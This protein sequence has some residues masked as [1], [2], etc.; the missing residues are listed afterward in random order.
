MTHR[1]TS[2]NR[3]VS[4]QK[5]LIRTSIVV[6]VCNICWRCTSS[7][8]LKFFLCCRDYFYLFVCVESLWSLWRGVVPAAGTTGF[9]RRHWWV[10]AKAFVYCWWVLTRSINTSRAVYKFNRCTLGDVPLISVWCHY[11]AYFAFVFRWN[12][13]YFVVLKFMNIFYDSR[14]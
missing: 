5:H 3:F 14:D 10:P 6:V 13:L 12:E 1:S 9:V 8:A 11:L 2:S 7:I 4:L